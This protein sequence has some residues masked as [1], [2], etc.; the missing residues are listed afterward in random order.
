[1]HIWSSDLR[2]HGA[3]KLVI[4]SEVCLLCKETY[5]IHFI[6]LDMVLDCCLS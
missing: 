5:H 3:G 1:M 4:Q 6:N 2:Q